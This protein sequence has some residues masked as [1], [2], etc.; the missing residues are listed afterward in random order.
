MPTKTNECRTNDNCLCNKNGRI[1]QNYRVHMMMPIS[2]WQLIWLIIYKFNDKNETHRN[3]DLIGDN[4]WRRQQCLKVRGQGWKTRSSKVASM[5]FL[6]VA[7]NKVLIKE[8]LG[9]QL[10]PYK[11]LT[12]IYLLLI[13]LFIHSFITKHFNHVYTTCKKKST[14]ICS[15]KDYMY[16][17]IC[18]TLDIKKYHY[19]YCSSAHDVQNMNS[20]I[21]LG[22][23]GLYPFWCDNIF[24][25]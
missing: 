20:T 12:S 10:C 3:E 18:I 5:P 8:H 16:K 6:L 17:E 21:I 22:M 7:L 23:L 2:D 4:R 13:Y 25:A 19:I 15:R 24:Q 1:Q 11:F 14:Q 9:R